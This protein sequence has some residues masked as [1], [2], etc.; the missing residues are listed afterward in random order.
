MGDMGEL[1]GPFSKRTSKMARYHGPCLGR[2]RW[3]LDGSPMN[4]ADRQHTIVA[5]VETAGACSYQDLARLL[6]VSEMTIRRDVDKLVRR[7][8]LIKGLGGVQTAHAPEHF[9]ESAVEQRLPVRRPQ[10]EQIARMASEQVRPRQTVF[11]DGGTTCLVLARHLAGK[12]RGLTVVTHSALACMEVGRGT[13]NT[14]LGLG[15]QFDPA[16][17]CFVGPAAEEAARR[18]F[19]DVAFLSTKGFLPAEGTFESSVATF[20][21]KQIIA[22]QAARVVLLVDHS[23]FGQRALCK[24][25]DIGQIHEVITD[26]CVAAADVAILEQ[27]GL[28]VRIAPADHRPQDSLRQTEESSS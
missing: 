27:R 26:A 19:V 11:L 8:A 1:A 16:S 22:E 7:G 14:I 15:G 18:Y 21:I 25:L 2:V 3:F 12:L 24:V 20:R 28:A 5:H 13:E 10:K 6:G 4:Q 23:K 17:A 9:Y